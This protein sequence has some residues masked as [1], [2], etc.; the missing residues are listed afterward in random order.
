MKRVVRV[1]A[2]VRVSERV[3]GSQKG[4]RRRIYIETANRQR[5]ILKKNINN[6]FLQIYEN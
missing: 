4:E 5:E 1:G 3:S 6:F 2:G